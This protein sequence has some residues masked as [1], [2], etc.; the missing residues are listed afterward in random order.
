MFC[1]DGNGYFSN[2]PD[3]YNRLNNKEVY[4]LQN[5]FAPNTFYELTDEAKATYLGDDGTEVGIYGGLYPYN[6]V[7]STPTITNLNVSKRVAQG[8][9]LKIDVEA[10]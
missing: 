5:L 4:R 10:E 1:I 2:I 9:T 3:A 6:D 8:E 7:L